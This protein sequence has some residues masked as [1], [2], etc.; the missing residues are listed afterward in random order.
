M[1]CL[2]EVALL[3]TAE[4]WSGAGFISAAWSAGC[5]RADVVSVRVRMCVRMCARMKTFDCCRRD[6]N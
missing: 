1:S 6:M 5:W 4:G 2:P 3:V